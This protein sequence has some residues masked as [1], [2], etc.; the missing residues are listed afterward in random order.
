[1]R[2][3]VPANESQLPLTRVHVVVSTPLPGTQLGLSKH[4]WKLTITQWQSAR[5]PC[6]RAESVVGCPGG[7]APSHHGQGELLPFPAPCMCPPASAVVLGAPTQGPMNTGAAVLSVGDY[8]AFW[9]S[10]TNSAFLSGVLPSRSLCAPTVA[11]DG[12]LAQRVRVCVSSPMVVPTA[13]GADPFPNTG[14]RLVRPGGAP[15]A[16]RAPPAWQ[17]DRGSSEDSGPRAEADPQGRSRRLTC[18]T[19]WKLH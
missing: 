11:V 5:L 6:G 3:E 15:L 1:M 10:A 16:A 14:D 9:T 7:R 19:P 4:W 17:G 18:F 13:S 8:L 12:R 2:E